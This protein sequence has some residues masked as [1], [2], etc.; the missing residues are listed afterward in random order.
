[1]VDQMRAPL[2]GL[3]RFQ[4]QVSHRNGFCWCAGEFSLLIHHRPRRQI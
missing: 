2:N 4:V 3:V 1:L